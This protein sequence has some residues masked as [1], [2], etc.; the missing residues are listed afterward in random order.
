MTEEKSI[1]E[2]AKE[3]AID[4]KDKV[5]DLVGEN[6]DK[7]TGAIDKTGEFVDDKTKHKYTE[8]I[9]RAQEAAKNAVS[10]VASS[11]SATTSTDAGTPSAPDT[12]GSATSDTSGTG[13]TDTSATAEPDTPSATADESDTPEGGPTDPIPDA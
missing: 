12:S 2:K 8:K 1:L 11:G 3:L 4:I 7:I 13:T 5:S 6:E 9:D 10:K